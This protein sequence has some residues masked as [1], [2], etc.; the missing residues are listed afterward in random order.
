MAAARAFAA[1]TPPHRRAR[2]SSR[3]TESD[4]RPAIHTDNAKIRPRFAG[5]HPRVR[6][7]HL[8]RVSTAAGLQ[9][10]RVRP[11]RSCLLSDGA[12]TG[13]V[14]QLGTVA[15]VARIDRI[16]IYAI[17][18]HEEIRPLNA[19]CSRRQGRRRGILALATSTSELT[20]LF[21]NL[22]ARLSQEYVLTYKSLLGPEQKVAVGVQVSGIGNAA[23]G[24]QTPAL[25]SGRAPV[26]SI[27]RHA[28]LD[29]AGDH[30]A[31]RTA[32]RRSGDMARDCAASTAPKRASEAVGQ[33][34]FRSRPPAQ[35]TGRPAGG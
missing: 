8:R 20:P 7:P 16:K 11:A 29:V 13:S 30:G 22:G 6:H 32:S 35:D 4:D 1:K 34:R 24:Y 10:G 26:P 21:D 27:A 5:H 2:R 15:K 23:A 18:L 25:K 14:H 33:V 9:S 28:L 19:H 17:G 3:S 12:D 31:F